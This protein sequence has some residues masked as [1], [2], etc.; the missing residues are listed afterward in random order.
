VDGLAQ[1]HDRCIAD[2]IPQR[3][4]VVQ[5]CGRLDRTER[6]G[7]AFD[8]PG[9]RVRVVASTCPAPTV[10]MPMARPMA[11]ATR[12]W[13]EERRVTESSEDGMAGPV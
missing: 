11:T 8:L 4:E 12:Q 6:N 13:P 3:D 7:V 5:R 2:L 1:P 9:D 10:I